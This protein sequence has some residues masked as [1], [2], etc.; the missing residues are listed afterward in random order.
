MFDILKVL[1]QGGYGKVFQVRKNTGP[2]NG[3]IYAMKVLKKVF[4][5]VLHIQYKI[6]VCI[7]IQMHIFSLLHFPRLSLRFS[8]AYIA[9][10]YSTQ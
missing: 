4:F 2:D 6:I 7:H 1:G 3:T 10:F 8:I 5:F 9:L